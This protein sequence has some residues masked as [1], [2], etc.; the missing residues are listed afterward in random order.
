MRG[1]NCCFSLTEGRR[2]KKAPR[3]KSLRVCV[4]TKSKKPD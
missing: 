1:D 3:G 2:L 4:I